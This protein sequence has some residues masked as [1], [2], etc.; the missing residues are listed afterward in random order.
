MVN[1]YVSNL[2]H[3]QSNM[4]T[5]RSY[6]GQPEPW[7]GHKH[8]HAATPLVQVYY[9]KL[10]LIRENTGIGRGV[11]NL[12]VGLRAGSSE[13]PDLIVEIGSNI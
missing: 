13:N 11:V 12:K 4:P 7:S 9:R 8:I 2:S 3:N 1:S 5:S 6:F 10:Q